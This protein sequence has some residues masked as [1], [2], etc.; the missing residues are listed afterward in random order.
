MARA[1]INIRIKN[2]RLQ[3]IVGVDDWERE[4]AQDVI[5][6]VSMAVDACSAVRNDDIEGT[7]DYRS[8]VDRIER[9]VEHSSFQLL[10]K[11]ADRILQI[12][13]AEPRVRSATVEVEKP[14][15]L[16]LVDAVSV[17]CTAE[18]GS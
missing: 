3:A 16:S 10:E 2:L 17:S 5:V 18:R 9:E 8:L 6:N 1:D 15:A 4:K 12:I 13:M 14:G 7:V 11:L